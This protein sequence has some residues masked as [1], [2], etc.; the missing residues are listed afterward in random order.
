MTKELFYDD[1]ML[2]EC[3]AVVTDCVELKKGYGIVLDQT[4]FFPEGGGQ[5][6]DV[7]SLVAG[8][9]RVAVTHVRT[10]DGI[11]YH[12]TAEP[13]APDTQVTAVLDWQTRMDHMQQH[14]GEHLLSYAF[15]QMYGADNVGFHMQPDMVAIDLSREVTDAEAARAEEFANA[16]IME[17]RPI[18]ARYLPHTEAA[19]L[20]TRKFN[21]KIAG[22]LRIVTIEGSDVCTCCGTHPPTTG[23][24]GPVKIFKTEKHKEGTRVYF[25][26]GRLAVAEIARRMSALA[27]AARSLSIKDEDIADGVARLADENKTLREELHAAQTELIN[28]RAARLIAGA[29]PNAAGDL[30]L[31]VLDDTLDPATARALAQRLA[32]EPHASI[33]VAYT[34]NDRLNYITARGTKSGLSARER[35]AAINKALNGKGGGKE[36]LAQGSAPLVDGW[37]EKIKSL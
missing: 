35:L 12:E 24:I 10:K 21:D 9:R 4:V 33:L 5:L 22:M 11:I 30:E 34:H 37:Q 25:L 19:H 1:V 27:I 2:R 3:Q 8:E 16:Q 29:A 31:T 17:D 26:C 13:I 7:G 36:N 18:T 23:M 15:W 14:A 28:I 20:T 32:E 6:S